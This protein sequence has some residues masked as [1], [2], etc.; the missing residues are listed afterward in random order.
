MSFEIRW[1]GSMSLQCFVNG[2]LAREAVKD[3]FGYDWGQFTEALE[4]TV[5][6]NGGCHD[7]FFPAGD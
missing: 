3:R 6:G 2:S 7:S 5:P 1:G 4:N